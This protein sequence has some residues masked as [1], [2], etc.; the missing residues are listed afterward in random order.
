MTGSTTENSFYMYCEVYP[1]KKTDSVIIDFHAL[2]INF[3]TSLVFDKDEL[4]LLVKD[5]KKTIERIEMRE[6]HYNRLAHLKKQGQK[7]L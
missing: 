6:R 4:K 3:S 2:N 1:H 5:M 7:T